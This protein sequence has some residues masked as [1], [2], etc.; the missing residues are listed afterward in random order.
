MNQN[1]NYLF[2]SLF[3]WVFTLPC[4]ALQ[5]R[6]LITIR[7]GGDQALTE[8]GQQAIKQT[9]DILLTH[10][11]DNRSI[12]AVYVAPDKG[13]KEC[14][15]ILVDLGLFTENKIHGEPRLSQKHETKNEAWPT[16]VESLEK[17]HQAGHII[18]ID[19]GKQ[20]S[21]IIAVLTKAPL[22]ET[23]IRPYILPL[24]ASKG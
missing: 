4:F 1:K 12:A 5:E 7:Q 22:D 17:K 16:F 9:G 11:F 15:K 24:V 13:S 3:L 23:S 8:G 2:L 10:G 21:R 18:L 6:H 20:T 19:D 14:A